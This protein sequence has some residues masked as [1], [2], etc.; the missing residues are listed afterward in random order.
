MPF[1]D[2]LKLRSTVLALAGIAVF[3]IAIVA[4]GK[5]LPS[6]SLKEIIS[7]FVA[8]PAASFFI[9]GGLTLAAYFLL[10]CY[11]WSGLRYL[12]AQ[13]TCPEL[14]PK[15]FAAFPA[16]NNIGISPLSGGAIRYRTYS[17][18]RLDARRIDGFIAARLISSAKQTSSQPCAV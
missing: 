13:L 9:A 2:R 6:I 3:A 12:H 5:E 16:G 7:Q 17:S 18:K 11:D 8:I 15:A 14:A 1:A 4:L 10:T